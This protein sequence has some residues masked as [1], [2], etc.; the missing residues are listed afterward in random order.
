MTNYYR[1]IL[2]L[3]YK[4]LVILFLYTL[5]RVLFFV[6]N[7]NH[8]Y[9]NSLPELLKVFFFGIRFDYSVVIFFNLSFIVLYLLPF[10]F[11][12]H[13]VFSGF[14]GTLF[15]VINFFLLCTNLIDC[16][17]FKY[18]SKRSTDDLFNF[19]FLSRDVIRLLPKFLHDFWYL[20][21]AL[22]LFIFLYWYLLRIN[23]WRNIETSTISVRNKFIITILFILVPGILF[24]AA[25][26]LK[27]KPIGFLT[28]YRYTNSQNIPLLI[29]TPFSILQTYNN[30]HLKP[31]SY[32]DTTTVKCIYNPEHYPRVNEIHRN[33]NIVIIILESFSKEFIGSLTGK[34]TYTP[35][36]DSIINKGLVFENTFANGRQSIQA[37]P[38][39]LAG[40]P[41]LT[42]DAFITSRYSIDKLIA[43]P[44]ILKN[45]GYSTAFFHGGHNGTMGFDE[46]SKSAGINEYYGFNEYHGPEANDGNWGIYDEEY[47][48]YVAKKLSG[49]KQPFFGCMFTL[50]SHHP[51]K[52]PDKFTRVFNNTPEKL[53]KSIRYADYALGKFF[54]TISKLPWYNNT[55]FIL[56]ADHTAREGSWHEGNNAEIYRIGLI[57]FHPGDSSLRGRSLRISGQTDIMPSVIDYLGIQTPYM[58]FGNSVFDNTS[59][60][61]SVNFLSGVYQLFQGNYV[62]AFDGEKCINLYNFSNDSMLKNNLITDSTILTKLME[63]KLKA[64]IQQ[65][66]NRILNNKLTF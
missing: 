21:L 55:L 1:Q 45:N 11:V 41:A 59:Q 9:N 19:I 32:F 44:E 12:K 26:G 24:L 42:D 2:Q 4:L 61:F 36:L 58:A 50:S 65:H 64:I 60:S 46:F 30:E 35:H 56:V 43:L 17:Y 8:F 20:G 7:Y 48:Q 18:T 13:K 66:N 51:Y 34:K 47:L 40:L 53:I 23:P 25:R 22:L 39:I 27:L 54:S 37:I 10:R 28:A 15:F 38:A 33:D 29:N 63:N 49:F 57:F 5:C 16:E 6:L 3:L 52:I 31:I 14:L 62:L